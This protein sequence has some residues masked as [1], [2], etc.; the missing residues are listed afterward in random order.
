MGQIM[1]VDFFEKHFMNIIMATH[2]VEIKTFKI[3]LQDLYFR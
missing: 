2:W 3:Y 1:V